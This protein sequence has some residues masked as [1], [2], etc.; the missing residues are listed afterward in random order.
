MLK[1][2]EE[3][4]VASE[5]T[6]MSLAV[7]LDD[8]KKVEWA[9]H[10]LSGL[11]ANKTQMLKP[12]FYKFLS[13]MQRFNSEAVNLLNLPSDDPRRQVTLGQYLRNEGYSEA[14]ASNYLLP[15]TAALWSASIDDVLAYPADQLISFMCNHRMLSIFGRPQV[16]NKG[17]L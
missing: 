6:D 14:F 7:S 1:W 3:L 8:G 13:D 17:I 15:M 5:E 12:S 4:G 11:I 2:F 10:G 16:S 9:S